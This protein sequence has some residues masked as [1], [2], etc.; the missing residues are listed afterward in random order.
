[1]ILLKG[2][3]TVLLLIFLYYRIGILLKKTIRYKEN[4]LITTLLYGFITE[5]SIFELLNIPFI[6]LFK[7]SSRIIYI[8]FLIINV[9]LIVLSYVIYRH[10]KK[11]NVTSLIQENKEKIKNLKIKNIVFYV[12]AIGMIMFQTINSSLLFKQDADDSFYISWAE[13]ACELENFYDTDPSTG[14]QNS[15]FNYIYVFNTWEIYNGFIARFFNINVTTFMHTILQPLYIILAYCAYYSV[16]KKIV[17]KENL[18]FAFFIL[19]LLF[20]FTG[21]SEKFK[22]PFLLGRIHQGKSIFLNIAIPLFIYKILEYKE[23]KTSNI[24]ILCNIYIASLAL[25]PMTISLLSL[26]YGLFLAMI[27]LKREYK[28]ILKLLWIFIPIIIFGVT[29]VAL[30]YINSNTLNENTL[31]DE[32]SQSNELIAFIGD[33]KP[34]VIIYLISIFITFIKGTETQKAIGIYFPV[35]MIILVFNPILTKIYLRL[36]TAST[37]WRLF[38]L[39]PIELTISLATTIIYDIIKEKNTKFIYIICVICI[40]CISGKYVYSEDRGFSKFQTIEKIPQYILDEADYISKNSFSKVIVVAPPEPWESCMLRQYTNDINLL[41]SRNIYKQV[42]PIEDKC[43]EIYNKIYYDNNVEIDIPL[44]DELVS[45]YNV[46]WI[47]I[48]KKLKLN[49]NIKYNISAENEINY[50]LKIKE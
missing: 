41:Y 18:G 49:D 44:I 33:G 6:L 35:I 30:N 3:M 9:L 42:N 38:W 43:I 14:L 10:T 13:E 27:L 11:Y 37:Y 36:V 39:V 12:L 1:M 23:N 29:Y 40:I 2:S 15:K 25:T 45:Q 4:V 48:P 20:L 32:F 26:I 31:I 50:L 47:I 8:L 17:K 19:T 24:I 34:I 22:G 5:L 28:K 46:N 16:L 21:V 7:H